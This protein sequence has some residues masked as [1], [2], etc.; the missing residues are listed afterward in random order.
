[1]PSGTA[2]ADVANAG[3]ADLGRELVVRSALLGA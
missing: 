1:M 3:A 2:R